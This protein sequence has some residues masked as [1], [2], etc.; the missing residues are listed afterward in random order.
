MLHLSVLQYASRMCENVHAP[1]RLT[2]RQELVTARMAEP[3]SM[4]TIV[5]AC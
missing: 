2:W 5:R 3:R 1:A 4:V